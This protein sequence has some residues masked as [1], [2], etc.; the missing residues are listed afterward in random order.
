MVMVTAWGYI[1]PGCLAALCYLS[2]E[3]GKLISDQLEVRSWRRSIEE[4]SKRAEKIFK[5]R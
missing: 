4:N 5:E 3:I 2:F 1:E